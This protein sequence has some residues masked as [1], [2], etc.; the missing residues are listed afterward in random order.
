MILNEQVKNISAYKK[1]LHSKIFVDIIWDSCT[2]T[3]AP[4][5]WRF[6]ALL[7]GSR[8]GVEKFEAPPAML[9]IGQAEPAGEKRK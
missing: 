2:S 8:A 5:L 4:E 9:V 3:C 1:Y 7:M 6:L